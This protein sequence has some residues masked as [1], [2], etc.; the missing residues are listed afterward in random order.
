MDSID[1]NA[2]L[3]EISQVRGKVTFDLGQLELQKADIETKKENL[4][5]FMR[6]LAKD[7]NELRRKLKP[8]DSTQEGAKEES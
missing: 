8:L 3:K 1:I 5:N 4:F 2:K 6:K 7:E